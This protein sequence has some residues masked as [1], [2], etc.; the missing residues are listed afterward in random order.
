MGS[1]RAHSLS[2]YT[3][4]VTRQPGPAGTLMQVFSKPWY[5]NNTKQRYFC[6][7]C[8]KSYYDGPNDY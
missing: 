4:P 6:K 5:N 3:A 1:E 7:I 2:R 8:N